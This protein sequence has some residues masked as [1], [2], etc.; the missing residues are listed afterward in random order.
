MP[1]GVVKTEKEERLW[2]K[3]KAQAKEQGKGENYA[4]I[5][6]IFKKM[7]P[8]RFKEA[9]ALVDDLIALA[10]RHPKHAKRIAAILLEAGEWVPGELRDTMT[11]APGH[12]ERTLPNVP[13]GGSQVPPARDNF[14]HQLDQEGEAQEES[15]ERV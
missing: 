12:I 5:T 1:P 8:E 9:D 15:I 14:G 4:Y 10:G 6:G 3:A 7:N 2:E 13:G 11:W